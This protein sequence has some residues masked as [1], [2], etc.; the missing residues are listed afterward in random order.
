MS[1]DRREMTI[2]GR[3]PSTSRMPE[4]YDRSVCASELLLRNT[5]VQRIVAGRGIAPTYRLHA[6]VSGHLR[7]GKPETPDTPA[8]MATENNVTS[9]AP[10]ARYQP[11]GNW[12]VMTDPLTRLMSAH[13]MEHGAKLRGRNQQDAEPWN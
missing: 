2:I 13:T 10:N 8:D 1:F 12:T 7:I 3:L 9:R 5:I 4:R 11:M 6:T